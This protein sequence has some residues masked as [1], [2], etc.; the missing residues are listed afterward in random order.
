MTEKEAKEKARQNPGTFVQFEESDT[1]GA[2][3]VMEP[4]CLNCRHLIS[5]GGFP[6]VYVCDL[7]GIIIKQSEKNCI[8]H[9]W[10]E[11]EKEA[12]DER[13]S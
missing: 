13:H 3:F 4:E 2:I 10:E 9:Q 8:Y 6:P 11:N 5:D 1:I 7:R 12:A